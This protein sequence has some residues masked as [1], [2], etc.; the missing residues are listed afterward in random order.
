MNRPQWI[1]VTAIGV[2]ALV[3]YIKADAISRRMNAAG[4]RQPPLFTV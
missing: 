1:L 3:A 4:Y 2:M